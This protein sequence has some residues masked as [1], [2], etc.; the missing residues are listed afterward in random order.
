MRRKISLPLKPFS[1]NAMYSNTRNFKTA[2][3]RDWELA[4]LYAILNEHLVLTQLREAFDPI[5]HCFEVEI[6]SYVPKA[7]LFT[8]A[9]TLSSRSY[10]LSNIEKNLIDLLFLPRYHQELQQMRPTGGNINADDKGIVT[11]RSAKRC[12]T[13]DKFLLEVIVSIEPLKLVAGP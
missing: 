1:V 12:S 11:L 13:D 5:K 9:G 3:Y 2:A 10:D 4:A 7:I 6:I 8:K